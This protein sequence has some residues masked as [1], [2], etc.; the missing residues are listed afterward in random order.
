MR[1]SPRRGFQLTALLLGVAAAGLLGEALL[2]FVRPPA[3]SAIRY[4]CFYEPDAELGFRYRPH[5]HGVVAGHFEIDNEVATNSLGFY[6]DEPLAP[7]EVGLRVLAFG[8]SF[9]AALNVPQSEVW[10]SV[11]ERELRARGRTR[12][13]VVNLGLDGT[14]T[15]VHLALMREFVP[16]LRPDVVVL[17]FFANDFGDV[18]N[19]RFERECYRDYVLS[20]QSAAQRAGLR[21]RVDAHLEGRLR[22]WL[23]DHV[24]LA[25]L[26]AAPFLPPLNPYRIQFLQ[27]RRSE[28]AIDDALRAQRRTEWDRTLT[29]LE[30][31]A[32]A[33]ACRLLVAPVPPRSQADG[34]LAM[35]HR[36]AGAR[37]LEVVDLLPAMQALARE[38]GLAHPDLY[39]EHDNHLNTVGNAIYARALANHLEPASD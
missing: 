6:D 27:P 13:D 4:P 11:L 17:A 28:L 3:L 20:Y 29:D 32:A 36:Q 9:T 26:L 14:G 38:S 5:A 33:C 15:D 8:D 30:A 19:G 18:L 22:R 24:Y 25:R 12:A 7:D 35:W 39:F 2:R 34:S 10:T 23:H 1:D 37:A 16:R 31:L 21:A